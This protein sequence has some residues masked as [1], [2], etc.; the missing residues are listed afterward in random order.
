MWTGS[1][2]C[3]TSA[4]ACDAMIAAVAL[5]NELPLFTCN[6][7]DFT[8]IAGLTVIAIPHPGPL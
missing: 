4:R 2:A 7:A 6:P 1:R 3:K 8:G 5:A